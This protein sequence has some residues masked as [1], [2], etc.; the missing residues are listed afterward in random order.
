[1][2]FQ[3][4]AGE[5]FQN[6]PFI[7]PTL[8]KHVIE[9]AKPQTSHSL[10][11]AYCGG[12]LFAL[13]ASSHFQKVAGIE[14][15][16]EGFEGARNN[17]V[18]N[19]V[20]NVDFYLGDASTIFSEVGS[21]PRPCSLIIDPPRKGCDID[22]LKQT[23]EFLPTRIVYVSC[24]PSTQARDAKI[25]VEAGYKILHVQPFDLFPQTRHIENVLTLEI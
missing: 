15:S 3:F 8:V 18:L 5:F 23:L 22:F 16:R 1:M 19:Q 17:A 14:I 25:L 21:L 13:S 12:G 10:I 4:K 11:D 7:L 24:D 2:I 9:S 6:N 20:E